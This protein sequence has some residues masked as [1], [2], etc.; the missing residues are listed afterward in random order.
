LLSNDTAS[1]STP[2]AEKYT[3]FLMQA[4]AG[5]WRQIALAAEIGVPAA[6]G[7]TQDQWEDD[8]LRRRSRDW[9]IG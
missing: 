4:L 7:L 3:Q 1:G 5:T 6:L 8:L 9:Q 2:N